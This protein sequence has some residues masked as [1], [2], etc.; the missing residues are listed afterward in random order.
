MDIVIEMSFFQLSLENK[1]LHQQLTNRFPQ[2][3]DSMGNNNS[4]NRYAQALREE[5]DTPMKA[6]SFWETD[7]ESCEA[8]SM[9]S[10]PKT[11]SQ[12]VHCSIDSPLSTTVTPKSKRSMSLPHAVEN[13]TALS[14]FIDP[15]SPAYDFKRTPLREVLKIY[16][17]H[18]R[19]RQ[20]ELMVN[21][22][23]EEVEE[24]D[25]AMGEEDEQL[26]AGALGAQKQSPFEYL[27][28][29]EHSFGH[30]TPRADRDSLGGNYMEVPMILA[31]VSRSLPTSTHL[32]SPASKEDTT[33]FNLVSSSPSTPL[34]PIRVSRSSNRVNTSLLSSPSTRR[35]IT[36]AKKTFVFEEEQQDENTPS[37]PQPAT[38]VNVAKKLISNSSSKSKKRPVSA[39]LFNSSPNLPRHLQQQQLPLHAHKSLTQGLQFNSDRRSVQ[40]Y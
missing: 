12:F 13:G 5:A 34:S 16:E 8:S 17:E 22:L 19:K 30:V 14:S 31:D 26:M 27:T 37:T 11:G 9:A 3:L 23:E 25:E 7:D 2:P 28:K 32:L 21:V 10:T 24:E 15:R 35:S 1:A 20:A 18:L 6:D 36:Q 38:P 33:R 40:W 29:E 39:G 4:R